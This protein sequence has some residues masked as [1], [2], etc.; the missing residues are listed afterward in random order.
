MKNIAIMGGATSMAVPI[1][2]GSSFS[3]SASTPENADLQDM[4]LMSKDNAFHDYINVSSKSEIQQVDVYNISGTKV[5]C[6]LNQGNECNFSTSGMIS[7][8]Y[9]VVVFDTNGKRQ[10][11]KIFIK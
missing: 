6:I 1:V 9:V 7:G 11:K 5:K 2:S 8:V 4:L 3:A 10:Q